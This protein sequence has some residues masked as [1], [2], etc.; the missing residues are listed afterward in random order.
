MFIYKRSLVAP[1]I[2]SCIENEI[3]TNYRD[4][5]RLVITNMYAK[6]MTFLIVYGAIC[7]FLG[8]KTIQYI[9]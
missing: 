8:Y 1:K 2:R 6:N 9:K 4:T 3:A 5:K 7:Y